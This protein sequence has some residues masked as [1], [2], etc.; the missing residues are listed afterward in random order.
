LEGTVN[1]SELLAFTKQQGASD[2][3][4]STGIPPIIRLHGSLRRLKMN[5]L[6]KEELQKM[7]Y[8]ILSD[9]QRKR[10]ENEMELDF[11][12]SLEDGTRF[13]VNLFRQER[14]LGA[15]FRLIPSEVPTLNKLGMPAVLAELSLKEKGLI[16][17]TGPTGSGKSTTL[18]AMVNH[19]N[20]NKSAHLITVED[21]IEFV[22]TPKNCL[23]NQRELG[24]HTHSFS[25]ALKSALREDPD[26]ILVGE[27][28]D[29]ETTSLAI[30]AAETGHLVMATLHTNSAAKTLDRVIDIFPADARDQVRTMLSESILAILAQALIPRRDGQGRV[31]ALEL[32][33]ANTAVRNLIRE[34]KTFQIP[35]IIQTSQQL[36]MQ[37]LDAHLKELVGKGVITKEEALKK[38]IDPKSFGELPDRPM[39]RRVNQ[40]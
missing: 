11:S 2:L 13:R 22:H 6:G 27:M 31:A 12:H 19:V 20:E 7:L 28:R 24:E 17:V 35:S 8:V 1:I 5:S 33:I 29:L 30:T 18:A 23:V 36:G 25:A 40:G 14:G 39:M 15:A 10:F 34:G 3:H 16:L 9:E 37:T 21:P 32:L 38:A 26:V 4:L